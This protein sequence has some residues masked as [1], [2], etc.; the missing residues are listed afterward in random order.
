M[1][2]RNSDDRKRTSLPIFT[3]PTFR[4]KIHFRTQARV[5][6]NAS[7]NSSTVR[8]GSQISPTLW[9]GRSALPCGCGLASGAGNVLGGLGNPVPLAVGSPFGMAGSFIGITEDADSFFMFVTPSLRV[10]L[11]SP[12]LAAARQRPCPMVPPETVNSGTTKTAPSLKKRHGK[13]KN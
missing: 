1:M 10:D 2:R 8:S 5:T 13:S 4:I 12:L 9:P 7:A 3:T 11:P 6:R